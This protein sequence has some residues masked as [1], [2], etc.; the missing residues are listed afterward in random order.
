MEQTPHSSGPSTGS[1]GILFDIDGVFFVGDDPIPGAADVIDWADAAGIPYLFVTNTTSHPRSYLAEKL[2]RCGVR[3][4]A[5]QIL[6][7]AVAAAEWLTDHGLAESG[8]I[9]LFVPDATAPDF[10]HIARAPADAETAAAVVVGDLGERW[11]FAELNRAF[12]LLMTVPRPVVIALGMARY[13]KDTDGLTLDNGPFAHALAFASGVDP[14]VTGKPAPAFFESAARLLGLSPSALTM[15]GDDI[16]G[17]IGGAQEAGLRG[18]LVR[19]GKFNPADLD[20]GITPD[21]VLDS[22]AD[23]PTWWA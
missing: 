4:D 19:T 12:R 23:L 20:A 15:V 22:V 8:P 21:A 14:V 6:T 13:W 10:G 5:D 18:V 9:A 7:P 1:A 17:D 3:A 11:T 2:R 16:R